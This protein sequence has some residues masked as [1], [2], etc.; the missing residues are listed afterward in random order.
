MKIIL[1]HNVPK[2]LRGALPDHAVKTAKEMGWAELENGDLLR[3]AE[4]DSFDLM[5]TCDQNLSYQQNMTKRQIA[6]VVLDTNNWNVL[7]RNFRAIVEAVDGAVRGGFRF[8]E[9]RR[10]SS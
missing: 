5:I 3:A 9:I 8:L 4:A 7:Q 2:R 1:D 6:L 10:R